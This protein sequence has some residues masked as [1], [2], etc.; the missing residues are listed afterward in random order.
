MV[1]IADRG[2][3]T[4][5]ILGARERV[6]LLHWEAGRV[7][8]PERSLY[9]PELD[10]WR[11]YGEP[12]AGMVAERAVELAVA[13]GADVMAHRGTGSERLEEAGGMVAALRF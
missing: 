11:E 8:E 7:D 12:P 1:E 6:R 10:D 4:G 2:R 9:E 5:L 13:S 3:P